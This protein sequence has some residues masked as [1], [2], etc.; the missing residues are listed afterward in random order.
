MVSSRVVE[1]SGVT[2]RFGRIVAVDDVSFAVERGEFCTLLG[3]SGCGKT[4]LLRMIAGFE[5]PDTGDVLVDGRSCLTLPPHRRNLAMVFQGYAL[6]PH[7]TVLQN[8]L[9]GL[10]MRKMGSPVE[11]AAWARSAL[12][13]VGLD[14]Y[15]DRWPHQLSGGQ[16]Q[17]VALARALVLR[18]QVLL[19]DEPLGALDLKLRKAMRYELKRL[20]RTTGISTIFVT[21]DQEEAMS[22]SDKVVVLNQ[23][24]LEQMG[25]PEEIYSAPRSA[26]VGDFIGES[27]LLP[28][29]V[30]SILHD[31][32]ARVAL[33]ELPGT[34]MSVSADTLLVL[35]AMVTVLVRAECVRIAPHPGD[36]GIWLPGEIVERAFLGAST[37]FY[38][39]SARSDRLVIADFAGAP[40]CWADAGARVHF[41]WNAVDALA[42]TRKP[43]ASVGDAP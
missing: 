10:R 34:E 17:R 32:T 28:A 14:G 25:R 13:M 42:F 29:T 15:E 19:L 33:E 20:Q 26:F 39:K 35:G 11:I 40:P 4:T 21:H 41:G 12:G 27:N 2:K 16:Q 18:P 38:L 31:G 43:A 37:R 8:V 9:F 1:F 22:M 5:F 24:R 7:R 30:V 36:D 23:G 3:P 6:F